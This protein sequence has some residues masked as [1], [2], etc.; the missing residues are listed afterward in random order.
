MTLAAAFLLPFLI[1]GPGV[2]QL[3]AVEKRLSEI[4]EAADVP[5]LSACVIMPDGREILVTKGYADEEGKVPMSPEHRFC[6]GSTGKM[7]FAVLAMTLV[8]RGTV[9]LD[10]PISKY[11]GDTEWFD[12]LPV[13]EGATLR[14]FLN[15][16]S[17]M[18]DHIGAPT[19][20]PAVM[21]DPLAD[22]IMPDAVSHLFGQEPI[23]APGEGWS[24]AD[25]NYILMAM[26]LEQ[27]TG[28]VAYDMI[29][30]L[31]VKPLKL[32]QTE[33]ATKLEYKSLANGKLFEGNPFGEGWSLE[34]GKF[35]MNPQF[36][37]AGGGY[38]TSP[39]DLARLARAIVN[40]KVVSKESAT[41][42]MDGVGARTGRGHKYGL[43]LEIRPT[44]L[45]TS[46]GH[47]G[48]YPGY[49]TDV[50]HF[51]DHGV[52]VAFQMNSDDFR[53]LKMNY[54]QVVVELAKA[55]LG[56]K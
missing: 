11:L 8:E 36:E 25:T 12:R 21:K 2:A 13:G 29:D 17:G 38:V 19:F 55:A 40:G 20:I 10:D 14:Q 45:G 56:R 52:T 48:W 31:T 35:K 26:A 53:A 54:Q 49:A 50:Q 44:D 3:E 23:F 51:P 7:H 43:G 41:M 37:W 9:S 15:H 1:A 24:Y 27:A 6:G 39:R 4:F 42:M 22:W 34:D 5:G 46:Y 32:T 47:S 16:T 28:K 18:R 30:G 33:P